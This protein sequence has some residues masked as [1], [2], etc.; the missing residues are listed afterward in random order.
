MHISSY[1]SYTNPLAK[2]NKGSYVEPFPL[3]YEYLVFYQLN[4]IIYINWK[5]DYCSNSIQQDDQT[6]YPIIM[7]TDYPNF[8]YPPSGATI[9]DYVTIIYTGGNRP[10]SCSFTSSTK[11]YENIATMTLLYSNK[12][13]PLQVIQLELNDQSKPANFDANGYIEIDA[14]AYI[15]QNLTVDVQIYYQPAKVNIAFRIPQIPTPPSNIYKVPLNP[16]KLTRGI[17]TQWNYIRCPQPIDTQRIQMDGLPTNYDQNYFTYTTTGC[18]QGEP[19]GDITVTKNSSTK[20]QLSYIQIEKISGAKDI[21]T[22]KYLTLTY[23]PSEDFDSF[24]IFVSYARS[25][26]HSTDTFTYQNYIYPVNETA[27]SGDIKPIII[28][29][30]S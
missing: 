14:S 9:Y 17:V 26:L 11:Y 28:Y 21:S 8:P 18:P 19:M 22:P 29:L 2:K 25:K 13:P 23:G 4:Q 1:I 3:N 16:L 30:V 5:Y 15:E 6:Y 20:I 24:P 27:P 10:T 7:N 12:Y